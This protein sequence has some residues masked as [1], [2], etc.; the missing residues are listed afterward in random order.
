MFQSQNQ[1]KKNT[2]VSSVSRKGFQTKT[3]VI[4]L[5]GDFTSVSQ[6]LNLRKLNVTNYVKERVTRYSTF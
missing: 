6:S 1:M 3:Y 5:L 4:H 2:E